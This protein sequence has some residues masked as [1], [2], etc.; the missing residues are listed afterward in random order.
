MLHVDCV[1]MLTR[2]SFHYSGHHMLPIFS[3]SQGKQRSHIRDM[4]QPFEQ[5]HQVQQIIIRR[6]VNPAFYRDSIVYSS[7]SFCP[8]NHHLTNIP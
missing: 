6:V 7:V 2:N 4:L 8:P 3:T 5:R 1:V